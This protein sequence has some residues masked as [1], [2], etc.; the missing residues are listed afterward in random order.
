[1]NKVIHGDCLEHMNTLEAGSVDLILTD[2]P[3]GAIDCSWD[4]VI[5]I[6][7][8]WECFYRVLKANGVIV[9]TASQPFTTRLIASN[10]S[11]YSHIWVW[12][13]NRPT[14]FFLA[15]RM[16]RRANEDVLVFKTKA[17]NYTYNPQGLR[18]GSSK[19]KTVLNNNTAKEGSQM[20][21]CKKATYR[22]EQTN[23]PTN[24]IKIDTD[25][26]EHT[27]HATQKPVQ[28][29]EYFIKTYSNEG[30]TVLDCC[31]GS[32][33]TALACIR[34]KRNYILIEKESKFIDVI[35]RR[36]EEENKLISLF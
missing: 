4:T 19:G 7:K 17:G 1:M 18:K 22:Q 12:L 27:L 28:L 20:Q 29:F 30:D 16:P 2:L 11:R 3:Y 32:G 9:L 25:H 15:K 35:N 10:Y 24:I 5:D 26:N 34:T 33:T 23:Y 6:E 36:I 14:G 21:K 8:M 13:K 31:A